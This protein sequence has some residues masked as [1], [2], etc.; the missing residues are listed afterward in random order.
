MTYAPMYA[1]P[2]WERCNAPVCPLSAT[3]KSTDHHDGE[4]TCLYLREWAKAGGPAR[5]GGMLRA[6]LAEAIGAAFEALT[7]PQPASGPGWFAI[8]KAIRAAARTGSRLEAGVAL[9]R[10]RRTA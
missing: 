5:V 3:W 9:R 2:K 1:C 7:T 6:D 4:P 10:R 8:R